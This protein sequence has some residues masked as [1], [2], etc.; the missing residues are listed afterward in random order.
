M[1]KKG[2]VSDFKG[3]QYKGI[4]IAADLINAD[5]GEVAAEAGT[6]MTPR[7]INKL[8]ESGLK[9][10][11]YAKEALVGQF[12]AED[13][14]NLKTGLVY[15]EAGDEITMDLLEALESNKISKLPILEIDHVNTCIHMID[16]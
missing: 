2:W 4:K 1:N 16:F 8:V 12:V 7:Y 9:K 3:A 13:I 11:L 14:V 5:T 6:K 10:I 15:A